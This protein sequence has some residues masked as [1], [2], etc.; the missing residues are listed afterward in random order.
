MT[1][2]KPAFLT[3]RE[4]TAL[5][6]ER[7]RKL[8]HIDCLTASHKRRFAAFVVKLGQNKP[9]L[10]AAFGDRFN[11]NEQAAIKQLL[12]DRVVNAEINKIIAE[13]DKKDDGSAPGFRQMA[14]DS[15][16]WMKRALSADYDEIMSL[17]LGRSVGA[18]DD[19]PPHFRSVIKKYKTK[20]P[21]MGGD[22][23]IEAVEFF[24][25][26]EVVARL[27]AW[28]E[29]AAQQNVEGVS[30][31][32]VPVESLPAPAVEVVAEGRSVL[33]GDAA[34]SLGSVA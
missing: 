32:S 7:L 11:G 26:L 17:V 13:A 16:R 25:K 12:A 3:R 29:L 34:A 15:I 2:D 8:R 28:A 22:P 1:D 18:L 31:V 30:A 6:N 20:I 9:A 5:A 10:Q 27:Q 19:L 4:E 14:V 23:V 24:D 21:R 33:S